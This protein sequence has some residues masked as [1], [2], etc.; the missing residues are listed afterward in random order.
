MT[1]SPIN[2][3]TLLSRL[4]AFRFPAGCER[5]LSENDSAVHFRILSVRVLYRLAAEAPSSS[6]SA[7]DAL[8]Q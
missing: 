8:Q 2:T 7:I 6:G 5:R 4:R 1:D 3:V